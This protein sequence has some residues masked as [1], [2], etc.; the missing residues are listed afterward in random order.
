V[1]VEQNL[2]IHV[3]NHVCASKDLAKE[4]HSGKHVSADVE[5]HVSADVEQKLVIH[6]EKHVSVDV[7]QDLVI[8]V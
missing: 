1:D 4:Y 7:E 3:R 8:H 2:M 6:A 5:N